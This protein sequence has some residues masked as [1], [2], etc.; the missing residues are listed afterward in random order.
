MENLLKRN[1]ICTTK[2]YTEQN[3]VIV[4]NGNR[5][6]SR[7][8][9]KSR[10]KWRKWRCFATSKSALGPLCPPQG[11]STVGGCLRIIL[12]IQG[13]FWPFDAPF[14]REF[15][16]LV[17]E[18]EIGQLSK[19][20]R[21]LFEFYFLDLLDLLLKTL[22]ISSTYRFDLYTI[23][24]RTRRGL[25]LCFSRFGDRHCISVQSDTKAVV[26]RGKHRSDRELGSRSEPNIGMETGS[27]RFGT[28]KER[29]Y[30]LHSKWIWKAEWFTIKRKYVD[31]Q[32]EEHQ[33]KKL[34]WFWIG[35]IEIGLEWWCCDAVLIA[36]RKA[37]ERLNIQIID[38]LGS[39]KMNAPV[40]V[41]VSNRR[42][43]KSEIIIWP[44]GEKGKLTDYY[45]LKI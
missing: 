42:M 40:Q 13:G 41:I 21:S 37:L 26:I 1:Q 30:M 20:E 4:R 8:V 2:M 5:S 27:N 19:I 28:R 9:E 35:E 39:D 3:L 29:L 25:A 45:Y 34:W 44:P 23:L 38:A 14:Y 36:S 12:P 11:F 17:A 18:S 16:D 24:P 15:E 31:S 22:G 10:R 32:T 7:V 43:S 33:T 6:E